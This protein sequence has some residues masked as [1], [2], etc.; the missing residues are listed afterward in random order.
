MVVVLIFTVHVTLTNIQFPVFRAKIPQIN[1]HCNI[2]QISHET[3]FLQFVPPLQVWE[4]QQ[5][6]LLLRLL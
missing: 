4:L 1:E 2:S 5:S 3:Y 6:T